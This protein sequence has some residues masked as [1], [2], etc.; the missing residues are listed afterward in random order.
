MAKHRYLALP[1]KLDTRD[2]LEREAAT[3]LPLKADL[4]QWLPP[5][6]DQGQE[7]S[8]TGF[9]GTGIMGW[10]WRKYYNNPLTFAPQF[11]YRCERT[12]E[13]DVSQDAGASSRTMML[14]METYGVCL[15]SSDPYSDTGWTNPASKEQLAEAR[16]YRIGSYARTLTRNGVKAVLAGGNVASIGILVY[17]SF[18]SDTVASTG[19][20]PVPNP[21]NEQLLGGHEIYI[22]GYD[23]TKEVFHV[24]NSWGQTWGMQ[25]NFTLPYGY[26][27]YVMDSWVA[28]HK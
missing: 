24:R 23:D 21:K 3:P 14:S 15:E 8:C 26:W 25:G 11:L 5:V 20:V 7:G 1:D 28:Y 13:G 19:I 6:R 18:E 16:N 10:M 27:P 17:D 12:I 9:A 22:F 2:F 4:S